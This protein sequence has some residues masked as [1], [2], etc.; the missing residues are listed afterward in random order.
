MKTM[1]VAWNGTTLNDK[2]KLLSVT[3]LDVYYSTETTTI[4]EGSYYQIFRRSKNDMGYWL[5]TRHT[6]AATSIWDVYL[7]NG[8]YHSYTFNGIGL[9]PCIRLG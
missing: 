5:R 3:E 9:A 1:A 4:V 2:V 8:N 6:S 7:G